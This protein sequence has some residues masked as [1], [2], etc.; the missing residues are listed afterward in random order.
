VTKRKG[1]LLRLDPA[2][3]DAARW[4]NDELRSTNAQ[5]EFLL[6]RARRSRPAA[7][8][9]DPCAPAADHPPPAGPNPARQRTAVTPPASA[10]AAWPEQTA[11]AITARP[12]STHPP[13]RGCPPRASS[14][15]KQHTKRTCFGPA[16][17]D[18]HAR[19]R[20]AI[21]RPD[22]APECSIPARQTFPIC[23][24]QPSADRG[25]QKAQ[26]DGSARILPALRAHS[27]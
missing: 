10:A 19:G 7:R 14:T 5:I 15:Q 17:L 8:P 9:R 18:G 22:P 1:I 24:R 12:A 4:A 27:A 13:G 21:T 26:I 25:L 23:A 3:H 6:R 11:P 2:V 20:H 16:R